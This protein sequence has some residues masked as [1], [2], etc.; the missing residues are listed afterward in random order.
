MCIYTVFLNNSVA[1]T[2][3]EEHKK[4]IGQTPKTLL[5]FHKWGLHIPDA[6]EESIYAKY[7]PWF[8]C[9]VVQ[10]IAASSVLHLKLPVLPKGDV[11]PLLGYLSPR[12][13]WFS[14]FLMLLFLWGWNGRNPQFSHSVSYSVA[15]HLVESLHEWKSGTVSPFCSCVAALSAGGLCSP[16]CVFLSVV[17]F[18]FCHSLLVPST[19]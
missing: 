3:R 11:F 16:E 7:S 13:I 12:V 1:S 8:Q 19:S 14:M 18:S 5:V 10:T 2:L 4:D 17:I 9:F 6:A 15:L